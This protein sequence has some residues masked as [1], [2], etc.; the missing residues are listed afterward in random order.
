MFADPNNVGVF[1]GGATLGA[2]TPGPSASVGA[3]T[4]NVVHEGNVLQDLQDLTYSIMD[5]Y[6]VPH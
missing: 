1:G 2:G 4:T 3:T 6:G 5:L